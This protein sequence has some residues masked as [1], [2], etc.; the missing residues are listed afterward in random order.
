MNERHSR[1]LKSLQAIVGSD[2]V[3]D[4]KGE[5]F[6][7]SSDP[8]AEPSSAPEFIVA[9]ETVEQ[10]QEIVKLANKEKI[11]ITPRAG[12]MTLSG[13]AI[14]SKGGIV[15]DLKRM[16]RIIEV[17]DRSMYALIECGVT[18]GDL[19]TYLDQNHPDLQFSIPGAP[20]SVSVIA[21][22]LIYGAGHI[23][24]KY[25]C[26]SD[27]INGLEIVLPTGEILKTGVCAVNNSWFS[28]YCLPDFTGL[29]I[30][31]F[32]ATGVVT[33]GAIQL[34]PKERFRDALFFKVYDME[35]ITE[36]LI[37][38][39]KTEFADDIYVNSWTGTSLSRYYTSERPA[40]VP[41]IY[42]DVVISGKSEKE[43]DLKREIIED[44]V[45]GE[46]KS[47]KKIEFYDPPETVR[48]G[49]LMLPQPVPFMD[50]KAGGGAEYLGCYIPI[51]RVGE[52]YREGIEIAKKHGFQ[53]VHLIRPLRGGHVCAV[54][55]AFPFIKSDS[56]E[57]KEVREM[58]IELCKICLGLGGIPWKPSPSLQKIVLEKADLEFLKLLKRV[59][60]ML[61]P[62]GIMAPERWSF[63]S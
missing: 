13:L 15:L 50:L 24:L 30:G 58:L 4:G 45:K 5:I 39:V 9:P 42:L 35:D 41:E 22:A 61:D 59:K 25:G 31:W 7:Y 57:V 20:P 26:N 33:K 60:E 23:S 62:N 21:N 56:N 14:P 27:M 38:L 55:Y 54:M 52:A 43:I 28:K 36:L 49:I 18:T 17:N 16:N 53:Y 11:P 48:A 46:Q 32:G 47:G 2:F 3:S 1:I 12:G 29:F 6:F 34:W 8:S 37:K 40:N 19:K 51:E 10:I 44:T 63:E